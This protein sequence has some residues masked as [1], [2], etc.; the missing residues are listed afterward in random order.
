MVRRRFTFVL[1]LLSAALLLVVGT[2][3]ANAA[4]AS[5][6]ATSYTS[7]GAVINSWNWLRTPGESA[8]WTFD[9][10]GLTN[11]QKRAVHL[12]VAALVTN[13]YNG[14]SGYSAK[15]V[16]FAV[17]CQLGARPLRPT[18]NLNNPFRP[19]DPADSGGLGYAAYGAS[20]SAM[21][22]ARAGCTT[23]TVTTSAPF[24]GG[25]HVAFKSDSVTLGY[26]R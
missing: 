23:L 12:N 19:I 13:T 5:L 14:G 2:G 7:N 17:T 21:N 20:T 15:G 8:T 11:P 18:V 22:L 10:S 4:A 24:T 1:A 26:R 16:K 3:S 9:V 6:G 25:R